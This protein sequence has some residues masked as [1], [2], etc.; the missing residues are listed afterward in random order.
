VTKAEL[1]REHLAVCAEAGAAMRELER[2]PVMVAAAKIH[3][4]NI[5]T[6]TLAGLG[7]R[8]RRNRQGGR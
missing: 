7:K 5:Q 8:P 3:L 2:Q 4:Q 1:K 6:I